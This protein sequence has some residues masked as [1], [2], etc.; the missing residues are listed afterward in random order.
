MVMCGAMQLM[1]Q[2]PPLRPRAGLEDWLRPHQRPPIAQSNTTSTPVTFF[3]ATK[4]GS[5]LKLDKDWRVGVT[6]NPAASASN[7]DDST[8]SVRNSAQDFAPIP[9]VDKIAA[10]P[11]SQG[12]P[13]P[14]R[15]RPRSYTWYRLHMTLAPNHG[16]IALL[17]ELPAALDTTFG[18]LDSIIGLGTDEPGVDVFVNGKLVHPEGPHGSTPERYQAITRI[19]NFDISPSETSLTLAVRSVNFPKRAG[20]FATHQLLLGNREDLSLFLELWTVHRLFERLPRLVNSILLTGLAIFLLALY[21]TQRSHIEYLWLAL[22][23]LLQAPIGYVEL[24]GSSA[25][26]DHR[27]YWALSLQLLAVSAYLY[28]EFLVAFLAKHK[29]WYIRLL[30]STAPVMIILG[31]SMLLEGHGPAIETIQLIARFGSGLWFLGWLGFVFITLI[32]A[33]ARRNF[34]ATLLFLPL[35]LT[36]V[37]WFEPFFTAGMNNWGGQGYRSLLTV[38]PV[39]IHFS[40]IADFTGLLAI[41]LIIFFRFLRI[42]H[43]QERVSSELEAARSVQELMIPQEKM[44]TPG[45]EVDAIYDPA[46]EVGGDFYH[47]QSAPDGGLLVVIGDVTGKGLKAAM[48]VSMLMGVLRHELERGPARILESLNR[49]L[50]GNESFTTCQALWFSPN[51][52]LTLAN[53]GHLPPYINGKE[54]EVTGS[55]PLGVMPEAKYEEIRLTMNPGDQILLLSDGVVEARNATGELFGF[56]RVHNLSGQ[57]AFYIAEAAKAFGQEDDITVLTVRRMANA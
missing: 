56:E 1:A 3:D 45:F 4:L 44:V 25:Q 52:E 47:V 54:V 46:S 43:D 17:V 16:K 18:A 49:V 19:Y 26:L 23:E 20:F 48:N 42:Q 57:S 12:V 13:S 33:T 32:T 37:G 55:L 36:L 8:W 6:I 10:P 41:M 40:A 21:M 2:Q 31:P 7:F 15:N 50:D 27:W 34:E 24:A 28:F 35:L 5:P 30:R 22:H 53:A 29:R 14:S 9:N 51:G 38:G 39:P 11:N